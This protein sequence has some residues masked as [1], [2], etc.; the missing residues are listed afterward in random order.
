MSKLH[1]LLNELLTGNVSPAC[2]TK[3]TF[4]EC[5]GRKFALCYC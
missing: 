4:N 5:F 1:S 3:H 2:S